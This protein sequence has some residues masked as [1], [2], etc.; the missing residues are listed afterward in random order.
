MGTDTISADFE[1]TT[2]TAVGSSTSAFVVMLSNRHTG[3]GQLGDT[4][5]HG[6]DDASIHPVL[7]AADTI[8]W[9]RPSVTP[10]Q[11]IDVSYAVIEYVGPA[12]GPNEFKVRSRNTIALTSAESVAS[13]YWGTTIDDVDRAIPFINGALTADTA[14]EFNNLGVRAVITGPAEVTVY[15]GA[16]DATV[17]SVHVTTVEFTGENHRIGHGTVLAST[18]DTGT[19][20]LV[21]DAS[22]IGGRS[23]SVTSWA[24]AV[25]ASWG[26]DNDGTDNSYSDLWPCL[27]PESGGALNQV[28]WTFHS[29]HGGPGNHTVHVWDNPDIAVTRYTDTASTVAVNVDITASGLSD[30]SQSLVLGTSTSSGTG[31]TYLRGWRMYDLTSLTVAR[32]Q[33]HRAG[34]TVNHE[35]QVIDFSGADTPDDPAEHGVIVEWDFDNDNNYDESLEDVTSDVMSAQWRVGRDYPSQLTGRS[36]PGL[37]RMVLDNSSDEYSPYN[38]TSTRNTGVYSLGNGRRVRVRTSASDPRDIAKLDRD[39]FNGTGAIGATEEGTTWTSQQGSWSRGSGVLSAGTDAS[40][41]RNVATIPLGVSD[42]YAQITT[43]FIDFGSSNGIVYQFAD[44]SN[45]HTVQLQRGKVVHW[46]NVAGVNTAHATQPEHE[47]RDG[48]VLGVHVYGTTTDVYLD[49]VLVGSW[50]N[51]GDTDTAMGLY[52]LWDKQR[53]P[54]VRDFYVWDTL[55]TTAPGVLWTGSIS[56]VEANVSKE[57]EKTATVYAVGDLDLLNRTIDPPDSIGEASGISAGVTAGHLVGNAAAAVGAL[58]PPYPLNAGDVTLGAVADTPKKAMGFVR[59]IEEAEVGFVYERPEGGIGFD[60]RSNRDGSTSLVVFSDAPGAGDLSYEKIRVRSAKG[61]LINRVKSEVSPTIARL[62]T[63]WGTTANIAAASPADVSITLPNE[64][65][66]ADDAETGDLYLAVFISSVHTAAVPWLNPL[67]WVNLRPTWDELGLIRVYA[68]V[69]DDADFGA[70]V[71]F[72]DD[73]T[74]AGGAWQQSGH[75]IK[76]WY[77]NIG[78]GVA[79]AFAG[80]G[81]PHSTAEA[82][83]G[84]NDP[85]TLITPWEK[86]ANLW[87][88]QRAGAVSSSGGATV[89]AADVADAPNGFVSPSSTFVNATAGGAY[90]VALQQAYRSATEAVSDPSAFLGQFDDFDY[91]E[92]ATIAVRPY[93]GDPPPRSGG[94]VVQDDN[95]ASQV[96]HNAVI[97]HQTPSLIQPDTTTASIYNDVLLTRFDQDRPIATVGF[98]ARKSWTHR[99]HAV[100]RVL[101][102]RVTV[103]A[104]GPSGQGINADFF[105]E[106]V[107]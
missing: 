74:P 84:D 83:A 98:T 23:F 44:T 3:G 39:R 24:N 26:H 4:T 31:S 79:A 63:L 96:D 13:T 71:V 12:D 21:Y 40:V 41:S 50:T 76:N 107:R 92:T 104:D 22:G 53:A 54:A 89:A 6:P 88:V 77:G 101:S 62:A 73:T 103:E 64:A 5:T 18:A 16:N 52:A 68:K 80:F 33:C 38:T 90:D 66:H 94:E 91:V 65:P 25:I 37:L 58:H 10:G 93:A 106:T 95:A 100:E 29:D 60:D 42:F 61:D 47:A 11:P 17:K 48:I 99:K 75:M 36:V 46:I 69:L 30:L 9:T 87:I 57:G 14:N 85:P 43:D 45:F 7:T 49:G 20:D 19:I 27:T 55:R 59:E 78:S 2:I 102:D 86:Q 81:V 8:T 15:G 51:N 56:R 105:V 70:T 67:G 34:N 28:D 35:L 82:Q 32:H 97:A 1:T 72:Y